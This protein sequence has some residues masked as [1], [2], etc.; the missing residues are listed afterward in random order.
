[1][2]AKN[3]LPE[4]LIALEAQLANWSPAES[5]IARDEV[6]YQCGWAAAE[7]SSARHRQVRWFWPT[8]SG[9]L[10]ATVLLMA[11]LLLREGAGAQVALE[12]PSQVAQ[13]TA[14]A[15]AAKTPP[16]PDR[17]TQRLALL[18]EKPGWLADRDRALRGD[19]KEPL[20]THAGEP[21]PTARAKTAFELLRELTAA[22]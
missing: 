10:A 16:A 2:P 6:M 12:T 13:P 17:P 11:T 21:Y 15:V 22:T 8:T 1:M 20:R 4:H 19:W 9:V 14:V 7:A 18:V 5:Q 3:H